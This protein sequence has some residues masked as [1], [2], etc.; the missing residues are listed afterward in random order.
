MNREIKFRMWDKKSKKMRKVESIGFGKLNHYENP[1]VNGVGYDCINDKEIMVHRDFP[2]FELMQYTGLK[3]KNDNKIYEGDIIRQVKVRTKEEH[4][5]KNN[6]KV[7]FKYGS[8]WLERPDGNTVYIKDFPTI[9]EFV[10]F[11]CFEVIG[12]VYENPE[13]LKE[14]EE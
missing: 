3:D 14:D 6:Y 11:E 8:F 7:V 1:V 10:G 4:I 12:N 5:D 9:D 13:L 2:H